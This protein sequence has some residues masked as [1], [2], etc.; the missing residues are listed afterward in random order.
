MTIN[1]L[2]SSVS[3]VKKSMEMNSSKHE[4]CVEAGSSKTAKGKKGKD[5]MEGLNAE[6]HK[7]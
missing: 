1:D 6:E 2:R 7:S 5:P 3:I 4:K